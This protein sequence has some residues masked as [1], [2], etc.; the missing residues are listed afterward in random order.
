MARSDCYQL[1]SEEVWPEQAHRYQ[2]S[3]EALPAL[4]H[5][6]RCYLERGGREMG[7]S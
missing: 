1:S 5:A 3:Q 4:D 6:A 2:G 7:L